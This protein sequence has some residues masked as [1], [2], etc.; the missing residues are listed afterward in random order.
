MS[1]MMIA[2][3]ILTYRR[4]RCMTQGQFGALL[5]VSAQAVSKWEREVCCPDISLLMD[6]ADIL[7]VPVTMLLGGNERTP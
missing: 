1:R 6:I 4:D 2:D 3:A 7:G 5:G